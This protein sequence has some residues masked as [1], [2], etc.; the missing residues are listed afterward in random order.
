MFVFWI[1][2]FV[3]YLGEFI[4]LEVIEEVK[5]IQFQTRLWGMLLI[6][7]PDARLWTIIYAITSGFASVLFLFLLF[8]V[9]AF[10]FERVFT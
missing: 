9:F 7:A 4:W 10:F 1:R 2:S 5:V 6:Y 8:A 3:H